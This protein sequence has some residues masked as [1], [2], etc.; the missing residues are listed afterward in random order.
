MAV[1]LRLPL[2]PYVRSVI[3]A[4]LLIVED[5]PVNLNLLVENL[6]EE[7]YET[8]TATTGEEG[9]RKIEAARGA[10]D[11]ILLDRMLPDTDGI[12]IL[13]RMQEDEELA[14]TPVILQTAM[15][16]EA[17]VAE[18]L[19][20]G[21]FYYLNKPFSADT[22]IAIVGAAVEDR[23]EYLALRNEVLKAANTL[24]CLDRAEFSFRTTDE[25]RNIATLLANVAPDPD[26]VVLGLSELMLNAVEHGNL[27]ITYEE[28]TRLI[29][30][31]ELAREI[32][33]RQ[34]Q[35]PYSGRCA[36]L[37]FVRLVGELRF[38]IRDEGNGFDWR[39]FLEIK[40]ERAFDTHG[41]GIAM[42]RLMSF[43]SVDYRGCGN[44]VVAV[45]RSG[46]A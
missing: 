27:G 43:Q 17:D 36:T 34:S 40:P 28:K 1:S 23:R 46:V 5:E 26:S 41:R 20:A 31:G 6:V 7:G 10:Y 45:V 15:V 13:R 22:L 18:G 29:A 3:P 21:A 32:E 38:I 42:A 30:D 19:A 4:R 8:D 14:R 24:A 39:E 12:E 35:P 33:R 44:E 11:A 37:E 9:W 16:A 25:A 2:S